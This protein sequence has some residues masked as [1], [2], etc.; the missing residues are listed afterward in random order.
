MWI[1]PKNA[2]KIEEGIDWNAHFLQ[3][4]NGEIDEETARQTLG[5]FLEHNLQFTTRI[6]TGVILKAFQ[7]VLI[8]GWFLKNFNLA[9]WGRG[10]GKCEAYLPETQ[11]VTRKNGLI[12]LPDLIPNLVFNEEKWIDIPEVELWNGNS[13]QKTNKVLLQ[14]SKDSIKVKTQYGYSL[15]GSTNH[16][17]KVWNKESC[18]IEWKIYSDIK[19]GDYACISRKNIKYEHNGNIN[20]DS[21]LIGL[22]LGD[23]HIPKTSSAN[24]F[25]SA[26]KELLDWVKANYTIL[27][28]STDGRSKAQNIYL[29]QK[30]IS[31]I[32]EK[33]RVK[34]GLSYKKEIPALILKNKNFLKSFL[35][36]LFD[37]DGSAEKIGR[38][39]YSTVSD[40]LAKQVHNSLLLF[41]IIAKLKKKKTPSDFGY[42]WEI[43]ISGKNVDMFNNEIGFRLSR[44]RAICENTN[45]KRNS[46][47]DTIPGIKE[48]CQKYIKSKYTKKS[49][50]SEE[51]NNEW[52]NNIRRKGNQNDLTYESLDRYIEFFE[53]AGV[54]QEDL[55]YLKEVK[56]ENFFFDQIVETEESTQDCIDFNV[57]NGEMYWSNGFISHNSSLAGLF[58]VLYCIFNPGTTVL[59]VSSNFRSSR[60]ILE[61]LENMC[62]PQRKEG[63]LLRQIFDGDLSRRNDIFKWNLF[64]GS[65]V[66]CLPLANGEGLRGQRANVLI[67]D[68][69]LLVSKSI[70]ENVLKPFLVASQNITEKLQIKEIEDRLIAKGV[71]QESERKKFKSTSKM[72][73]L[74]SAS[75]QGEYFHEVYLDYLKKI[76]EEEDENSSYFVSQL[77]YEVML[78]LGPE[79]LDQGVLDDV[80]SGN[81]PK[82]VIDR[83]YRAQFIQ[84]SDG[85]FRAKNL[86]Q[87]TVKD[88]DMPC[89]EIIG[90]SKADYILGIDPNVGGD[91][92]NDHFA[93]SLLKI[94]KK[95]DGRKIGLLVH[96]Y[97]AAGVDLEDHISYI[98]YLMEHFNIVYIVL[99]TSQGDN[100]DFMSVCN[101]SEVFKSRKI[102]LDSI[103]ADFGREDYTEIAKEVRRKYNLNNK[104]IVQNQHF[105]PAFI[106]AANDYLQACTENGNIR[107]ASKA[108]SVDGHFEYLSNQDIGNI[109]LKHKLFNEFKE[110]NPMFSF[111]EM[112]D[113]LI[114]LTKSEMAAIQVSV[115]DLGTRQFKLPR[116]HRNAKSKNRLRKDNY[117]SLMLANWGLKIYLESKEVVVE[118]H[119]TTFYATLI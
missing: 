101:E 48:Y 5:K 119:N 15:I 52:R 78:D 75:F 68:E 109:H 58:A 34:R 62:K 76:I 2:I 54:S 43:I 110:G 50:W 95:N 74:S 116:H 83:E 88:G 115:T 112:Q 97:A 25:T 104:K 36:G 7:S 111:I 73:L 8:K 81:T 94:I 53:R 56:Q 108:L 71:M 10:M 42:A 37:T 102:K 77:S 84:D 72:I 59:I 31:P 69:A 20:N 98:T 65:S 113:D 86:I 63:A 64:N 55:C 14:P 13:W 16:R 18:K 41:G 21:Y 47:T 45:T 93:M 114:D 24:I 1:E 4:L 51:I 105:H 106:G 26:D 32:F 44:K 57:P 49:G 117:S 23:G 46:N 33:Y 22:L 82:A 9:C 92:M 79:I 3:T 30:V 67:I 11:V 70:I 29:S 35:Q 28:E 100:M 39:S 118:Q 27:R 19:C 80:T 6:L 107:F 103:D 87:C 66:V 91:E 60:R 61:G 99:D 40:I 96:S 17:I 89:V 90:D 85:F 12:S 38:I